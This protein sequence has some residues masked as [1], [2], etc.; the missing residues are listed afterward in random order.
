MVLA[1]TSAVPAS[2]ERCST[3]RGAT[4]GKRQCPGSAFRYLLILGW[5]AWK[6]SC[7]T[8][9]VDVEGQEC[10][11]L[12]A[13]VSPLMHEG[14]RFIDQGTRRSFRRRAVDCVGARAGDYIVQ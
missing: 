10:Q 7:H 5:C 14:V 12:A 11:R 1:S 13:W 4:I 6:H 2:A 3:R 9:R 8:F